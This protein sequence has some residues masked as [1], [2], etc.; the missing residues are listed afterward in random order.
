MIQPTAYIGLWST[1]FKQTDS[2]ECNTSNHLGPLSNTRCWQGRAVEWYSERATWHTPDTPPACLPGS[3]W[4]VLEFLSWQEDCTRL[5]RTWRC[6]LSELPRTST[7]RFLCTGCGCIISWSCEDAN[8][9]LENRLERAMETLLWHHRWIAVLLP[10]SRIISVKK[11]SAQPSE[12]FLVWQEADGAQNRCSLRSPTSTSTADYSMLQLI[13][14]SLL[15]TVVPCACSILSARV[16]VVCGLNLCAVY[17]VA[18]C[19]NILR[20]SN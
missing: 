4:M 6:L 12:F 3:A 18:G 11:V 17:V 8:A 10:R 13:L 9:G 7:R 20:R 2:S 16:N 14:F 19:G 15:S 1:H 5:P